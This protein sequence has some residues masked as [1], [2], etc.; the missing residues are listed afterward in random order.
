MRPFSTIT[1]WTMS[2][3]QPLFCF[4]SDSGDAVMLDYLGTNYSLQVNLIYLYP[5]YLFAVLYVPIRINRRWSRRGFEDEDSRDRQLARRGFLPGGSE[6]LLDPVRLV[7]VSFDTGE[8]LV[9]YAAT[10]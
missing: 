10:S 1:A 3:E 2:S 5:I 6:G 7:A 4:V 8:G 9:H